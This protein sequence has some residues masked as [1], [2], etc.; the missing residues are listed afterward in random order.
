MSVFLRLPSLGISG[1][2]YKHAVPHSVCMRCVTVSKH[3][4]PETW[5]QQAAEAGQVEVV[6]VLLEAGANP[7]AQDEVRSM[8]G[9]D[10]LLM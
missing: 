4:S 9:Q 1:A 6:Q 8:E 2:C 5:S 3:I 10:S 7:Q